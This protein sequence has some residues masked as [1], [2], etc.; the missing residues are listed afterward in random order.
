MP[1]P[2]TVQFVLLLG[3]AIAQ[4]VSDR[5]PTAAARVRSQVRSCEICGGQSST[6]AGFPHQFS[7]DRLFHSHH[8]LSSGIDTVGQVVDSV[9]PHPK[10][11]LYYCSLRGHM[12]CC[13][14]LEWMS[15]SIKPRNSCGRIIWWV[16]SQIIA[17][18]QTN[19]NWTNCP[20][21][22]R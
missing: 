1:F 10:K 9:S 11:K 17:C 8:H 14:L 16:E 15:I 21:T 19:T 3:S 2:N 7:F 12:Y 22:G 20:A 18:E 4:A 6:G 5:L 13:F